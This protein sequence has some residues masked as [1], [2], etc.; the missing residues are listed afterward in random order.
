[1][2]NTGVLQKATK[3]LAEDAESSREVMRTRLRTFKE[4]IKTGSERLQE[5]LPNLLTKYGFVAPDI[6]SEGIDTVGRIVFPVA[7]RL[8]RHGR[9][10]GALPRRHQRSCRRAHIERRSVW[11]LSH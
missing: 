10:R 3:K 1:M 4:A 9:C 11:A 6:F 8:C 5:E 7:S 2:I